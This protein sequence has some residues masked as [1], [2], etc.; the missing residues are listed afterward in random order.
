MSAPEQPPM[1]Q[2]LP[3]P[4]QQAP[5]SVQ[6]GEVTPQLQQ[7]GMQSQS[8]SQSAPQSVSKDDA[9]E[10]RGLNNQNEDG[11]LAGDQPQGIDNIPGDARPVYDQYEINSPQNMHHDQREEATRRAQAREQDGQGSDEISEVE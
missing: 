1:P 8:Q 11:P 9:K 5:Q 10:S 4:D 3:P 6:R 7:E 2:D